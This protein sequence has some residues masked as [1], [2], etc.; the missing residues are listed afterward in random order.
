MVNYPVI[1]K[2][3]IFDSEHI[4][5]NGS[6]ENIVLETPYFDATISQEILLSF[7]H[8]FTAG[9]GS[10]ADIEVYDGNTWHVVKTYTDATANPE[11]EI[12]NISAFAG[13]VSDSK[14]RFRW[15]GDSTGF[16]AIDN[17][18]I[19]TPLPTDAGIST[20]NSPVMPFIEGTHPILVTLVN[21]GANTITHTT[22]SWSVNGIQQTPFSWTGS[23]TS[24]TKQ[25]NIAIGNY[26]FVA[27]QKTVFRIWQSNPNG[28]QDGYAV[29]DTLNKT[30]YTALC[31][32]YTLGGTDPD[33][34]SFTDAAIALNNAGITCPVIFKVR[35]GVYDEQIK[36]YQ[37]IGSSATNTIT[38][39]GESGDSSKVEVALQDQQPEQ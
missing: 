6:A 28:E 31:G 21:F 19:Y 16:W 9:N 5:T 36:L 12:L 26:S 17:I 30:L 1:G 2:F 18:S 11:K 15:K 35:D 14:I 29:N 20:L 3:A 38:F 33:F 27:G 24:G 25:S 23:L 7:D 4:S 10:V 37:I 8:Y 22:I 39:M 32:T 34:T 13:G